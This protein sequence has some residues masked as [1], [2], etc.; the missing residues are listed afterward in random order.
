VVFIEY[1]RPISLFHILQALNLMTQ[2][3]FDTDN[4]DVWIVQFHPTGDTHG[5]TTGSQGHDDFIEVPACLLPDFRR[6]TIIVGLPVGVVIELIRHKILLGIFPNQAIYFFDGAI[7]SQM[8]WGQQN[9]RTPCLENLAPFL[10]DGLRHGQEK[11]VAFDRT[12]KCQTDTCISAGGF[13]DGLFL[14][15]FSRG[16]P[17]FD[18]PQGRSI[19]DGSSWI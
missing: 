5:G 8:P 11:P 10:T 12:D 4:F 19:L 6:G 3:R 2:I 1:L 18:H 14:G 17:I 7:G 15:E 9:V 16:L 13:D